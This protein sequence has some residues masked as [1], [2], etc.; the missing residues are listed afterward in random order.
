MKPYI[1]IATRNEGKEL[2]ETIHSIHETNG[3]KMD[4]GIVV[5]D[6]GD[7]SDLNN[8]LNEKFSKANVIP[9]KPSPQEYGDF[10]RELDKEENKHIQ[11]MGPNRAR[12]YG[13]KLVSYDTSFYIFC[14]GH[15]KFNTK[16]WIKKLK[17][18]FDENVDVGIITGDI[19]GGLGEFLDENLMEV[20]WN[21]K[22]ISNSAKSPFPISISPA[23][24]LAIRKDVFIR[25]LGFNP[26]FFSYGFDEEISIRTW[27]SGYNIIC[28][29]SIK[30]NHKFKKNLEFKVNHEDLLFQK[31]VS[32][33]VNFDNVSNIA[34][35]MKLNTINSFGEPFYEK[36]FRKFVERE[37]S[38]S[39]YKRY[40]N[41]KVFKRSFKDFLTFNKTIQVQNSYI[42]T[43]PKLK[44]LKKQQKVETI[45]MKTLSLK[46]KYLYE[47]ALIVDTPKMG[48]S[49]MDLKACLPLGTDKLVIQPQ[50]RMLVKTGISIEL[51]EGYEAQV[52][53]R[54]GLALKNGVFV[55]N[56]IGTIDN[57]YKGEIGVIIQNASKDP[58]VINHGDRI[59][60]L[61]I[62]EYVQITN[63]EK[64]K[65]LTESERGDKGFGS[66][67]V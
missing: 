13:A 27:L 44:T 23:G 9:V 38:L 26:S 58:F 59:A 46:V 17:K 24:F 34:Y 40:F 37:E 52:R 12:N 41:E 45:K 56:G 21:T 60:Q 33:Y 63:V 55:L 42:T 36:M 16:D 30:I 20:K 8:L 1:V 49:G 35:S 19:D 48:D 51:P 62:A 4:Y 32:L 11:K 61:V 28:D 2:I 7:G 25:I 47:H 66:T 31:M 57:S 29:P 5:I 39:V 6:D 43:I 3:K 10:D 18:Y 53:S 65:D 54:S 50:E 64:I 67:G 14:D 15:L 22:L